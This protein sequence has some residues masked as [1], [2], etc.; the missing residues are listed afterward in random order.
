MGDDLDECLR[1]RFFYANL[2]RNALNAESKIHDEYFKLTPAPSSKC[3]YGPVQISK[4]EA[5]YT[6][7]TSSG[8]KNFHSF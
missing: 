4:T 3:V 5:F 2:N 7:F 8:G 1:E 6:S